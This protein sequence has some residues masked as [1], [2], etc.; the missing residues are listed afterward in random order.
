[1]IKKINLFLLMSLL[2]NSASISLGCDENESSQSIHEKEPVVIKKIDEI[3]L[4]VIS[5]LPP[6]CRSEMGITESRAQGLWVRE[7]HRDLMYRRMT[8]IVDRLEKTAGNYEGPELAQIHYVAEIFNHYKNYIGLM[9][10][11]KYLDVFLPFGYLLGQNLMDPLD[12]VFNNL[13][14]LFIKNVSADVIAQRFASYVNG[15]DNT[16]LIPA[17]IGEI[18]RQIAEYGE[19]TVYPYVTFLNGVIDN[20]T[21]ETVLHEIEKMLPQQTALHT[22]FKEQIT[23]YVDFV[24]NDLLPNARQSSLFPRPVYEI[25]LRIN[26][27]YATPEELIERGQADFDAHFEK[28]RELANK[29]AA[30]KNDEQRYPQNNPGKVLQSLIADSSLSNKDEIV[31]M[32]KEIQNKVLRTAEDLDFITI[33]QG[34]IAMRVGTDAEEATF[35]VPHVNIPPFIGNTG[36]IRSEFVLCDVMGNASPVV[37]YPLT[38]HEGVPG[39]VQQFNG[40]LEKSLNLIETTLAMNSTNVEGWAHY[41]EYPFAETFQNAEKLGAYRDHLLRMARIFLDPQVNLGQITE[42]EVIRFQ[43]DVV[44]FNDSTPQSEAKRYTYMC[45]G[46][47]TSYRYGAI[48]I[49][50]LRDELQAQ[51]GENFCLRSFHDHLLG[52]GLMPIHLIKND[53]VAKMKKKEKNRHFA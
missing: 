27:I 10:E 44:G 51:M 30:E 18:K 37:A 52:F 42:D 46:Q 15:N 53:L 19:E 25:L 24:K 23:E 38:V 32:Y 39:H 17:V 5:E 41:T 48:Q 31:A 16:P 11:Y 49:M 7:N 13:N 36:E 50:N 20:K 3:A 21:I 9:K 22:Q 8:E 40:M 29:I 6:E 26:G 47:A 45:P 12:F 35:P 2:L 1:M 28:Y 4:A 14:S 34:D 33:P 43:R